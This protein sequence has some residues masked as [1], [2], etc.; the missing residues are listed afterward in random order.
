MLPLQCYI[1][2]ITIGKSLSSVSKKS[3]NYFS[4]ILQLELQNEIKTNM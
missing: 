1:N 2:K 3:K 4:P